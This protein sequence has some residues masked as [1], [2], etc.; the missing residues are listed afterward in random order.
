MNYYC[1][2]CDL[3]VAESKYCFGC[4]FCQK[5]CACNRPKFFRSKLT[6][7]TP[8]RNQKK[9]NKSSRFISA[10]IE[11]SSIKNNKQLIEEVVA[12][13]NGN[14]VYDGT[15]PLGGFEINTAPAA[16]DLYSKQITDICDKLDKAGAMSNDEC[17]LHVHVDARDFNY[18][19]LYRLVKIYA[20][21]EP[22][23][24]SMVPS[25]RHSSIYTMRCADK[26][27]SVIK[28]EKI[29]HIELKHRIVT[30]VYGTGNSVYRTDKR[31]A[32]H[33]TGRYY[34]LNLHSWFFRGTV[35]CRLFDGTLD[36]N[37]IIN[38]GVLW[39]NILD[40]TLR[41]S[42]D[43]V[44]AVMSKQKSLKSLMYIVKGNSE[45]ELFID[46]RCKKYFKVTKAKIDYTP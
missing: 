14:I 4:E 40:F 9:I 5:C 16:G 44:S 36:K 38:W 15:L 21:I 31:G 13:W 28:T 6:F 35:E 18:A 26:L 33:G 27:E 7:Y 12:E 32:G 3:N 11:V 29:T 23:L 25:H 19:D 17:G 42:D 2:H 20:A 34:A 24:F 41:S 43:E 10:E 37:E 1:D 45:L 30:A 8:T 46:D 22:A 39:A